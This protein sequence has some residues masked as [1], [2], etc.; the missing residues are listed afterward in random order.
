MCHA[1]SFWNEHQVR[2]RLRFEQ[3]IPAL[4]QA[5]VDFSAGR[6]VHPVRTSLSVPEHHGFFGV[7]P[8]V[9][10]DIMGQVSHLLPTECRPHAHAPCHDPA[11]SFVH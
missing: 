10:G 5:L 1:V 4:K 7:M 8:A 11:I 6:V 2:E 3:L 9:Y